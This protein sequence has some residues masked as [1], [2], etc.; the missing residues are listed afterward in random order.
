MGRLLNKRG[1]SDGN[2][3][4]E[5]EAW[6]VQLAKKFHGMYKHFRKYSV[7]FLNQDPDTYVQEVAEKMMVPDLSRSECVD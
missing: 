5:Y 3:N 6:N 7:R 2:F 4:A 1:V